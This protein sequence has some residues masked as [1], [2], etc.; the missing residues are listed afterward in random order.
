MY[1]YAVFA[2]ILVAPQYL[3][4]WAL[5][6]CF[7]VLV[8]LGRIAPLQGAIFKTY[9]NPHVLE[10]FAGAVLGRTYGLTLPLRARSFWVSLH[11]VI[12]R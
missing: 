11:G 12:P 6:A 1:F 3:R 9:T 10:L 8:T 7:V 2:L 4:L 5:A